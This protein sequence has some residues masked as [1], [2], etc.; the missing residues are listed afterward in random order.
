MSEIVEARFWNKV[1]KSGG[2]DACWPWTAA[3]HERGYGLFH[4]QRPVRKMVRAHRFAIEQMLGRFLDADEVVRHICDNPPCCNP[5]HLLTGGHADNKADA[6][7]RLRH[8][9]GE[10]VATSKL[11]ASQ[12][13]AI[14]ERARA[15]ERIMALSHEFGVRKFVIQN[16]RDGSRFATSRCRKNSLRAFG[17]AIAASK[18]MAS[19]I[20]RVTRR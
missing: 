9:F 2:A 14:R 13:R 3:R 5:R 17:W 12:A 16:I 8:A 15:G 4:L 18:S 6:V 20:A 11:T 1:D 10:R 7:L 19:P